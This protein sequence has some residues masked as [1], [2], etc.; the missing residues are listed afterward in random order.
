MKIT[1]T[2][3]DTYYI[4]NFVTFAAY[5]VSLFVVGLRYQL[6]FTCLGTTVW[7]ITPVGFGRSLEC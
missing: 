6:V 5:P 1:K 7:A 2:T 3:V 4:M